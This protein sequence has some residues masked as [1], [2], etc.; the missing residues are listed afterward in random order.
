MSTEMV[1]L[2]FS[3]STL[4][5]SS[6]RGQLKGRPVRWQRDGLTSSALSRRAEAPSYIIAGGA[7]QGEVPCTPTSTASTAVSARPTSTTPH[8]RV[9][10]CPMGWGCG[11]HPERNNPPGRLL[12]VV[13]TS[14]GVGCQI[15]A[16]GW[17]SP[18]RGSSTSRA[19][20]SS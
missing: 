15:R 6:R 12:G 10:R 20:L 14:P 7:P 18:S 17:W 11:P 16:G 5:F 19:T 9:T 1:S 2:Y 4:T 13:G 8:H 3:V